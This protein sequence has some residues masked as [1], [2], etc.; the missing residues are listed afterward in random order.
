MNSVVCV[1]DRVLSILSSVDPIVLLETAVIS[2]PLTRRDRHLTDQERANNC[3][4]MCSL[5]NQN[6]LLGV[7]WLCSWEP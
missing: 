1:R 6:Y 5:L 7:V 4:M 2:S 3:G